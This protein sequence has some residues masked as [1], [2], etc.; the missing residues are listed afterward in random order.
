[1]LV[2][3]LSGYCYITCRTV[4]LMWTQKISSTS[5][6]EA[7][8][9]SS[10]TQVIKSFSNKRITMTTQN[11]NDDNNDDNSDDVHDNDY[12]GRGHGF[13]VVVDIKVAMQRK[14]F[15]YKPIHDRIKNFIICQQICFLSVARIVIIKI[16]SSLPKFTFLTT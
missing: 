12:S 15:F 9:V 10:A 13:S 2:A 11:D 6:F 3:I 5:F 16:F 14:A 7:W 1:M 8:V 4:N